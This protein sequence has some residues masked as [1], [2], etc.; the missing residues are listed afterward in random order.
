[1][2]E[3]PEVEVT[4]EELRR[5]GLSAPIVA[6]DGQFPCRV[7][8]ACSPDSLADDLIGRRI[9]TI[10]R[11]GKYLLLGFDDGATLLLHRGMSGGLRVRDSATAPGRYTRLTLSFADGPALDFSDPRLFGRVAFFRRAEDR[12]RYLARRLGRDA[13]APMGAAELRSLFGARRQAIKLLLLDQRLL[14]GIGSLYADETLWS[15]RVHPATPGDQVTDSQYAALA[16]A[17]PTILEASI[18]RG[19]TTSAREHLAAED[20]LPAAERPLQVYG[21]VG[22]PCPR[23]ATPIVRVVLGG[24][25][26]YFC[27]MC[28]PFDRSPSYRLTASAVKLET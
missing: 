24:R 16:I 4:A 8:H 2:P 7:F 11:R 23:C 15:V 19:G 28:Q 1:M 10:G 9:R 27:P 12:D 21:R 22:R 14:A 13:L 25:G 5:A 3:L 18:R 17:I 26:T 6:V 20:R